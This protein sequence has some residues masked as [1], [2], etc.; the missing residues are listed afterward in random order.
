M[1]KTWKFLA[2]VL[3]A[4][5][6]SAC[7]TAIVVVSQEG[8]D[9]TQTTTVNTT[10]TTINLDADGDG[11]PDRDPDWDFVYL[12]G[13]RYDL[14]NGQPD[15][16][17]DLLVEF[18]PNKTSWQIIQFS[19]PLLLAEQ[20]Y[21]IAEYGLTLKKYVR[22]NAYIEYLTPAAGKRIERHQLFRARGAV[23]TA[24]KISKAIGKVE[25]QTEERKAAE[26]LRIYAK[27]WPNGEISNVLNVVQSLDGKTKWARDDR[28]PN[29][30]DN[31]YNNNPA[32]K[33]GV[34]GY[35]DYDY[36][37]PRMSIILN[38]M[39]DVTTIAKLED[40]EWVE[41]FGEI[42]P[43]NTQTTRVLQ[44]GVDVA[45]P[46]GTPFYNHGID[47]A[48]E[49]IGHIDGPIDPNNAYF[50]D[51]NP[52]GPGHR[53]IV[54][55]TPAVPDPLCATP[56]AIFHGTHTAGTVA[57]EGVGAAFQHPGVAR[58]ARISHHDDCEIDWNNDVGSLINA[59]TTAHGDGA[60]VH[61]N[62]YSKKSRIDEYEHISDDVDTFSWMNR[63]DLFVSSSGNNHGAGNVPDTANPPWTAKNGLVVAAAGSPPNQMDQATGGVGP[64]K[65]RRKPEIY[66]DGDNVRSAFAGSAAPDPVGAVSGSSMATPAIAAGAALVRQYFMRGFYPD[67]AAK[68]S[69]AFEPS[70]ALLKAVLLNST[71]DMTGVDEQNGSPAPL[72]GYPTNLEGW[73]LAALDDTVY[74]GGDASR[75][76]VWD[77]ANN[78]GVGTGGVRTY[79]IWVQSNAP[80]L[81]ITLTWMDPPTTA[82][83]WGNAT[84][85]V[86]NNLDMIVEAPDGTQY[87]GNNY[88]PG[89]QS[90]PGGSTDTM[91]NVEQFERSSPQPGPWKIHVRGA[92][93]NQGPLQGYALVASGDL[94][95]PGVIPVVLPVAAAPKIDITKTSSGPCKSDHYKFEFKQ[96]A[97]VKDTVTTQQMDLPE[98]FC[99]VDDSDKHQIIKKP[100][101]TGQEYVTFVNT[102]D[103]KGR[104]VQIHT[105]FYEGGSGQVGTIEISAEPY[106][107]R[108]VSGSRQL[109]RISNIRVSET[110]ADPA[111][112]CD[113]VCVSFSVA[114]SIKNITI[115]GKPWGRDWDP[116][117]D[118]ASG[119]YEAEISKTGR[120]L[121]VDDLHN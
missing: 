52:V 44:T 9:T 104:S 66:T 76:N 118:D 6:V 8:G 98:V 110:P 50:A 14:S 61:T 88:G 87:F 47:G 79:Y 86:L 71:R 2:A 119:R 68:A 42:T 103:D 81:K 106:N 34:T 21:L 105:L 94:T 59:L 70:G 57:G 11:R 36:R 53:K 55:H 27:L 80:R 99:E 13:Y 33:N 41:E 91:N 64:A 72:N 85:P 43:D 30:I 54:R 101:R 40:V 37:Q 17:N 32:N 20:E 107:S 63:F 113:K 29:I 12:N 49:I 7:A 31:R 28:R 75:L 67:G 65:G 116:D 108:L 112:S 15:A 78:A 16:P 97:V 1:S 56:G 90:T 93:V 100:F 10:Q 58:K 24:V 3:G 38:S 73:G 25:F 121:R 74:F 84:M 114:P 46:L 45:G 18:D 83:K 92:Q 39:K 115:A 48:G 69:D 26:G 96:G 5:A 109:Q 35:A 77:I 117:W 120:V 4:L 62:S 60:R 82:G 51:A 89:A 95:A 19:R 111:D 23:H 102:A 22:N